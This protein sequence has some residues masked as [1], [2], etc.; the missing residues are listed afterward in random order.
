[1]M[2][3]GPEIFIVNCS[4]LLPSY[5]IPRLLDLL[6]EYRQYTMVCRHPIILASITRHLIR[7]SVDGAATDTGLSGPNSPSMLRRTPLMLRSRPIALAA[8]VRAVDLMERALR[9]E[10]FKSRL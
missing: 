6:P 5:P 3:A 2:G 1:M 10:V 9:G 8:A 7:G 4:G